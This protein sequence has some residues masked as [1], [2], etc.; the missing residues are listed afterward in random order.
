MPEETGTSISFASSKVLMFLSAS[1]AASTS[2]RRLC[3]SVISFSSSSATWARSPYS[4]ASFSL[5]TCDSA[6]HRVTPPYR[7]V[8][9]FTLL[10][11][12]IKLFVVMHSG[13]CTSKPK[14]LSSARGCEGGLGT[15]RRGGSAPKQP[16]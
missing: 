16:G 5:L 10:G 12:A 8:L 6:R 9:G 2:A 4:S 15:W 3:A 1:I 11:V 14:A 7:R 13:G